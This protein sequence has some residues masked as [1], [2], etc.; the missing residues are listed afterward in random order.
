MTRLVPTL[1]V[2]ILIACD[3]GP[4]RP[5]GV[6]RP[7]PVLAPPAPTPFPAP[8][9]I[10]TAIGQTVQGRL[11]GQGCGS[12]RACSVPWLAAFEITATT[13]G[14]LVVRLQWHE[15]YW[16]TYLRLGFRSG[17][18]RE[19]TFPGSGSPIVADIAVVAGQ[20]Y[21]LLLGFSAVGTL[22]VTDFTLTT[23]MR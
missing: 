5:S 14:T 22:P 9:S 20:S 16:D 8:T 7:E 13:T 4:T 12:S 11:D 18:D 15:M 2:S 10:P 3:G 23:A 6:G 19:T 1:C 17:D 21:T